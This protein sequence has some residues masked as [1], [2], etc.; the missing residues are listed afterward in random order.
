[1]LDTNTTTQPMP[2]QHTETYNYHV[3]T[4]NTTTNIVNIVTGQVLTHSSVNVDNAP[5]LGEQQMEEFERGLPDSFHETIHRRVTTMP[6]SQ[7]HIKV[8][9]IYEYI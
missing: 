7:K 8:M 1:M 3:L 2:L 4:T 6:V 9:L 5:E